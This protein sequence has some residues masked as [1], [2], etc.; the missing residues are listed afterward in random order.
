MERSHICHAL[1]VAIKM[2]QMKYV[3]YLFCCMFP[4]HIAWNDGWMITAHHRRTSAISLKT[5]SLHDI[6]YRAQCAHYDV[7][8]DNA[9][10][11]QEHAHMNALLCT[12][13][14]QSH[15]SRAHHRRHQ[16][17]STT[18]TSRSAKERGT[19]PQRWRRQRDVV[20]MRHACVSHWWGDRVT[21]ESI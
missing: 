1:H 9:T 14:R 11:L 4:L 19:L 5:L 15:V 10:S 18:T 2:H 20:L 6:G 17:H 21:P 13:L 3:A 12:L 7:C 8:K 16:Q